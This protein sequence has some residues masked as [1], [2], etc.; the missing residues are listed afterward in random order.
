MWYWIS[1]AAGIYI[2][3]IILE[4]SVYYLW[5][6]YVYGPKERKARRW[7]RIILEMAFIIQLHLL[8]FRRKHTHKVSSGKQSA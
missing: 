6:R 1:I 8:E 7:K 2:L 5:N 4:E 3:F